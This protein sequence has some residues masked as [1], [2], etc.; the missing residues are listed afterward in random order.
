MTTYEVVVPQTGFLWHGGLDSLSK[1]LKVNAL[2]CSV[3][4][5]GARTNLGVIL[6]QDIVFFALQWAKSV[7]KDPKTD[8]L[9][10]FELIEQWLEDEDSVTRAELN[11]AAGAARGVGHRGA[12]NTAAA[13]VAYVAGNAAYAAANVAYAAAYAAR[14]AAAAVAYVAANV[15]YV[16]AKAS[17]GQMIVDYYTS[18]RAK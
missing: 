3:D 16:A 17:Q 1:N 13:N 12:A 2:L 14:A 5:D 15:A 8:V 11:R 18:L 10:C 7:N 9:K 4:K 6:H